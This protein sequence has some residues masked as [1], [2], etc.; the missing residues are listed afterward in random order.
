MSNVKFIKENKLNKF[1]LISDFK[2]MGDQDQAVTEI[3]GALNNN[4]SAMTLLGA[5]G[6]GKTFTI[7]NVIENYQKP[8]LVL[9]PNRT[10][11]A[12]LVAEFRDFFPSNAVE[13]FG[14]YYVIY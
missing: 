6:T 12:Q 5:T 13:Y 11:A 14:S 4:A 1:S 3:T 8:T 10:L 2:L 9:A 7:A